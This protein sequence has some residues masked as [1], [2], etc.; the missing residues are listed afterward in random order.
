VQNCVKSVPFCTQVDQNTPERRRIGAVL[1]LFFCAFVQYCVFCALFAQ[2]LRKKQTHA[3]SLSRKA[4]AI[5]P[6]AVEHRP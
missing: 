6:R 4:D 3:P 2:E 1:L 5:S